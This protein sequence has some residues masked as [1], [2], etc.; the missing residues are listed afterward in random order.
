MKL[1]FF[2]RCRR[3]CDVNYVKEPK[4]NMP[5]AHVLV[6]LKES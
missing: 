1:R 2:V 5:I 6:Y 4:P 3:T